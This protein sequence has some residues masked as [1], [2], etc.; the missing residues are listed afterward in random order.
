MEDIFLYLLVSTALASWLISYYFYTKRS[1]RFIQSFFDSQ[2]NMIILIHR[3]KTIMI[4]KF[5]LGVLGY[6][7][8]ASFFA[9]KSKIVD[10]FIEEDEFLS[11]YTYGEKWIEELLSVNQVSIKGLEK[12]TITKVK[13]FSKKDMMDRFYHIKVSALKGEDKYI[14]SFIDITQL[15]R[16]KVSLK[17]TAEYDQLTAIYNRVKLDQMIERIFFN[18]NKYNNKFSMILFDIDHFKMINDNYGH[19]IGDM[20]LVSLTKLVKEYLRADDIFVRWGGEEFVILLQETELAESTKLASR[21]R[22]KIDNHVFEQIGNLT[23]S[24]GVTEVAVGD[25]KELL[26]DRVDKALY[27]AKANGR[28][29]VVA[30]RKF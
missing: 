3:K 22:A 20:I 12:K 9:S 2:N 18:F 21:L 15:E 24:F 4:N 10:Y 17:K 7:S 16:D 6:K 14:V 25:T 19:N 27:E 28:N 23:C 29:K 8:M 11:K 5:G 26:F 30:K 1:Q 13:I